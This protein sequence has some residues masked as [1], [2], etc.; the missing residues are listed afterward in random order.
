VAIL[1]H[2]ISVRNQPAEAAGATQTQS[3]NQTRPINQ[4]VC[5]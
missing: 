5:S 3:V 1:A 4:E 2:L